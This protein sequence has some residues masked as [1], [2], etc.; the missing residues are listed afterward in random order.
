MGPSLWY[1]IQTFIQPYIRYL[2]NNKMQ[3]LICLNSQF[4]A[5]DFSLVFLPGA[6]IVTPTPKT[7][8]YPYAT[9]GHGWP[10]WEYQTGG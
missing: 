5:F 6:T 1:K 8:L 3:Y 2:L 10:V 4:W 9:R 7:P